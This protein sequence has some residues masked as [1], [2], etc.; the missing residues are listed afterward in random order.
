VL[1][2]MPEDAAGR[3]DPAAQLRRE[4]QATNVKLD[5]LLE[6]L[7]GD[8]RDSHARHRS[9]DKLSWKRVAIGVLQAVIVALL[10]GLVRWAMETDTQLRQLGL[11][12]LSTEQRQ[13]LVTQQKLNAAAIVGDEKRMDGLEG[14][15]HDL[16]RSRG[17]SG[18]G[19]PP[20]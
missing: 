2:P 17:R 11:Q 7:D 1:R 5:R 12:S 16:E 6:A 18:G 14:R 3:P 15:I 10:F 19:E 13:S 9:S 8:H 4:F 20:P